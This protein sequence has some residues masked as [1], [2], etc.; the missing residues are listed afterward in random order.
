[1]S[2]TA[3]R[4]SRVD[5]AWLRMDNDVNLMMIVGVW[6]LRPAATLEALV[7]RVSDKLLKYD[8]FR[9]KVVQDAMGASWVVDDDFDIRRHVLRE[10]LAAAPGQTPEQALQARCGELATTPLDPAHPLWTFHLVEDYDGGSAIIARIH[11]CIGDGISLISVML[12]ITDGGNDPPKRR[13]REG[14]ANLAVPWSPPGVLEATT[15][16][17]GE[18]RG[19]LTFAPGVAL[20]VSGRI[21]PATEHCPAS[22][23]L[24][25]EGLSSV[26]RIKGYF[27]PGSDHVVG[28]IRC[29]ANDLL[30]QPDGTSGPFVLFP[31]RT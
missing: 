14:G 21:V 15:D 10:K 25:G 2:Q 23:E 7:E 11:H 6:L 27:I 24:T 19:T 28:T 8:R 1:M 26:N 18:V 5:T 16:A 30:K 3:E 13:K 12:S 29:V 31:I 22:V 20:K 4:M 17:D 9:Q